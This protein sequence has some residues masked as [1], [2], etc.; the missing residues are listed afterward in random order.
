[1]SFRS[2]TNSSKT[3]VALLF[4]AAVPVFLSAQETPVT[5]SSRL[6]WASGVVTIT[7]GLPLRDKPADARPG[8]EEI[9]RGRIGE[10]FCETMY[11]V[12]FDSYRTVKDIATEDPDTLAALMS[13]GR[14]AHPF[15]VAMNQSLETIT[16]DFQFHLFPNIMEVFTYH[17]QPY[18][19][20]RVLR[21]VPTVEYSGIVVY[22]KG[23]YAV[24]G[25]PA[26][27]RN[28]A[29]LVP[30]LRPRIYDTDMRLVAE[31]EMVDPAALRA[32]GFAAFTEGTDYLAHRE[33]VGVTPLLTM[34][35]G[36]FGDNR[37]DLII[38]ADAADKILA[39]PSNRRLLS[40]GRI[41]IMYGPE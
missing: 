16:Y 39:S 4:L 29:L 13:I 35:R 7:L 15:R 32:W 17:S 5:V 9:V 8:A 31:V 19:P 22:A 36:L 14:A 10:S 25:E 11:Q 27:E 20:A 18:E 38:Q 26:D 1:M 34:A 24:H 28:L 33:R 12:P 40:Q 23:R 3:A 41:L 30:S 37:T 21:F 2:R 6:N